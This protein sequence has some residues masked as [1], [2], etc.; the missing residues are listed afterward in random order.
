MKSNGMKFCCCIFYFIVFSLFSIAQIFATH[1]TY[2]AIYVWRMSANNSTVCPKIPKKLY[3]ITDTWLI[4]WCCSP[5]LF[6]H[7]WKLT[8]HFSKLSSVEFEKKS[9]RTHSEDMTSQVSAQSV[10]EL[11]SY[12]ILSWVFHSMM[13]TEKQK[14]SESTSQLFS[15]V[16]TLFLRL[17]A[18]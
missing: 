12:Q 18:P 2:N 8:K 16:L 7:S 4:T 5:L 10:L 15:R 3:S 11:G 9:L 1:W 14:A 6:L 13:N 17:C